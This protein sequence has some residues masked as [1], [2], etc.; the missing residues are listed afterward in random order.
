MRLRFSSDA[1]MRSMRQEDGA[2]SKTDFQRVIGDPGLA[3]PQS[4]ACGELSVGFMGGEEFCD[5]INGKSFTR[6]CRR[7][8]VETSRF[9]AVTGF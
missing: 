3:F 7:D 9:C 4:G 6:V 8:S 2:A 5:A 1:T